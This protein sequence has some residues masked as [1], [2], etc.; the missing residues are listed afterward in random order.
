MTNA[1]GTPYQANSKCRAS[2]IICY[3]CPLKCCHFLS[4]GGA[5]AEDPAKRQAARLIDT[6][7]PHLAVPRLLRHGAQRN[8]SRFWR[9]PRQ[10]GGPQRRLKAFHRIHIRFDR[11]HHH[12]Q[13]LA[14]WRWDRPNHVIAGLTP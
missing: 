10:P 5:E 13:M 3:H 1:R 6:A 11:V 4:N 7:H 14:V 8:Q 12:R 2:P 9:E